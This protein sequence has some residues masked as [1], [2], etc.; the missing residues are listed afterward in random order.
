MQ[1]LLGV[2]KVALNDLSKR[3]IVVRGERRGTYAFEPSVAGYCAHPHS[4][5]AGRGGEAGASARSG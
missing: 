2:G 3:G 4:M 1:R 5:A